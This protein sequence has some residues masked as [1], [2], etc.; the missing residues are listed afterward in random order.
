MLFFTIFLNILQSKNSQ[1]TCMK[2][3]GLFGLLRNLNK[4]EFKELGKFIRSPYHNNR[5]ELS[6][7]Y[8]KLSKIYPEFDNAKLKDSFYS[9][10]YAGK[11]IKP[12]DIDRLNSYMLA[13]CRDY[14]AHSEFEKQAVMKRKLLLD[15]LSELKADKLFEKEKTKAL[16]EIAADGLFEE[17]YTNYISI[18]DSVIRHNLRNNTQFNICENVV[19]KGNLEAVNYIL[20]LSRSIVD[21]N[22]NRISF[23]YGIQDSLAQKM[24]EKLDLEEIVKD[25]RFTSLRQKNLVYYHIYRLKHYLN[26]GISE[27]YFKMKEI[28][29][30]EASIS[31]SE[32]N[33]ERFI[34]LNDAIIYLLLNGK[35]EFYDESYQ[36]HKFAHVNNLI[37]FNMFSKEQSFGTI[38]QVCISGISNGDSDFIKGYL[39]ENIHLIGEDIR[40]DFLKFFRAYSLLQEKKYDETLNIL[41]QIKF[42]SPL[43]KI[44]VRNLYLIIY[45]ETNEYDAFYS[46]A[47]SYKKSLKSGRFISN[48]PADIILK[49]VNL[50]VK[51]M[52]IKLNSKFE[53]LD[54][55][56]KDITD[57]KIMYSAKKWFYKKIEELSEKK[58]RKSKQA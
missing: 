49:L 22:C 33:H 43:F 35:E 24:A 2:N 1:K 44:D 15:K 57:S 8:N 26:P 27:Y 29:F 39:N 54:E 9:D 7:Y 37:N 12:A 53:L 47:E 45:Y 46:L 28:T 6:R 32:V 20:K 30:A 34:Q 56:T 17:F 55:L 58:S 48:M 41:G 50:I 38:R 5:S 36:M 52:N 21:M 42:S 31:S 18:E 4:A 51:L 25:F 19:N 10:I 40:E 14:L 13:A 3:T 16:A 11:K 23:G